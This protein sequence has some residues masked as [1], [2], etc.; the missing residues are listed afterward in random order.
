MS[1]WLAFTQSRQLGR[2][3]NFSKLHRISNHQLQRRFLRALRLDAKGAS[4]PRA[5]VWLRTMI[6]V[7][8]PLAESRL[9]VTAHVTR[10]LRK[11][12]L[13]LVRAW[14]AATVASAAQTERSS[15]SLM[16]HMRMHNLQR[17]L[18]AFR[19]VHTAVVHWKR[20][21]VLLSYWRW[22]QRWQRMHAT[23]CCMRQL[24]KNTKVAALRLWRSGV[25]MCEFRRDAIF[26][27][28][29]LRSRTVMWHSCR[30]WMIVTRASRHA[31]ELS[32]MAIE[33]YF[34]SSARR[35]FSIW[36]LFG[37]KARAAKWLSA[38]HCYHCRRAAFARLKLELG[39]ARL[40]RRRR[41]SID[42]WALYRAGRFNAHIRSHFF[43]QWT[44]AVA[45]Q[46]RARQLHGAARHRVR[47]VLLQCVFASWRTVWV[48]N[49]NMK[50]NS[51]SRD[52]E[53]EH[54]TLQNVRA[55]MVEAEGATRTLEETLEPLNQQ[56]TT[57]QMSMTESQ[58]QI[59]WL[60]QQLAERRRHASEIR[61]E[62]R[63]GMGTALV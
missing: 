35:H 14:R 9:I 60:Q 41:A 5:R 50:L 33:H 27:L 26:R 25:S 6:S 53:N 1:R 58:T 19:H 37:S 7:C 45:A 44:D 59:G 11:A 13:R 46:K 63:A 24:A 56:M 15:T 47:G 32:M 54:A 40:E 62:R 42:R 57:S 34:L 8:L 29:L 38:T 49:R 12:T 61:C 18:H 2:T 10:R 30:T 31:F 23:A 22:K 48:S 16:Q 17:S 39:A 43:V 3:N 51:K 20:R 55:T 28:A 21:A 36:C 52:R 4:P